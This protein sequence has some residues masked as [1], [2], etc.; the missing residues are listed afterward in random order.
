MQNPV[1]VTEDKISKK[2][3]NL[4]ADLRAKRASGW[5]ELVLISPGRVKSDYDE[6]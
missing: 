4:V 5:S 6:E 3:Q 2:I 1:F